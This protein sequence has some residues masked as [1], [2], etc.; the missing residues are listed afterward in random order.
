[1]KQEKGIHEQAAGN[2]G[3]GMNYQDAVRYIGDVPKFTKKNEP[4]N[5][6]R[7]LDRLGHPEDAF[8]V[9]HVAG[10]NGK[11]SVCAFLENILRQSGRKTGLF[12][13]PH[14][15]RINE[16]FQVCREEISDEEFTDV[17]LEVLRAVEKMQAEGYPHPTYFELLFVMGMVWFRRRKIDILVME[18]GLGGRLDATSTV[19]HPSLSVISSIS[20]DHMQYLGD[21]I[22]AI[23]AEKA[24]IIKKG[25]PVVYDASDREA[26][27]LIREKAAAAGSPGIPVYP[28]MAQITARSD[29]SIDF[30]LNNR[31][32]DYVSARVPFPADYQVQ[33]AA[34]AMTALRVFDPEKKIP[35]ET[36][37][38]AVSGTR[39]GGRMETAAEGI[40]LDGAHN[41][42][43]IRNFLKTV[44]RIA[45]VRPV[46]LLFTAAADKDY[47]EMIREIC[48]QVRF[49]FIVT[50]QLDGPRAVRAERLAEL[51]RSYTDVPVTAQADCLSAFREAA[52]RRGDSILF[53][54]GSLYMVGE[55]RGEL[56]RQSR[57]KN[58]A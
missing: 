15:I 17:F 42:D 33:N 2:R 10:T 36:V 22:R 29:K 37:L 39:W 53:C 7:L 18:T 56:I 30:V 8:Q 35:D 12:T 34:L 27:E 47:P 3:Q 32:Y 50:T 19:A 49:Q 4:E 23:A 46:S 44:R 6:V 16:R 14:L 11:G 26:A 28:Q 58:Q 31:Y 43:G 45:C 21:T 57:D 13:S 38:Q 52:A 24:G 40:I 51:F 20:M 25:V 41:A 48:T 55:I 9:I 54:A 5:T 1:M